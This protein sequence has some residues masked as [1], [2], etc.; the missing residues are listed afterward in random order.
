[1]N[2]L[3]KCDA[4]TCFLSIHTVIADSGSA[5]S[6]MSVH[7]IPCANLNTWPKMHLQQANVSYMTIAVYGDP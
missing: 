6:R 4:L 3:F 1:M 5:K 7:D 2:H